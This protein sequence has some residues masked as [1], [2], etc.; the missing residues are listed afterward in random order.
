MPTH[1]V[2]Q[3]EHISSIADQYGF[4]DW[5]KIWN[6][7][8][9]SDLKKKREN[10]HILYPDDELFIPEKEEKKESVSNEKRH[11]FKLKRK[12]LKLRIILKDINDKPLANKKCTLYVG[13]QKFELTSK[14]NGLVEQ[15][16]YP[17]A[18]KANLV[19][20]DNNGAAQMG[21]LIK[22]GHLDPIDTPSGQK[23]RLNNL[24][25]FAGLAEEESDDDESKRRLLAAIEEFQCD[26]QLK[27][28]GICGPN[29]Q[30]KLKEVYGS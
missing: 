3:G 22:I 13:A 19:V 8:N 25:Y 20:H 26:Q 12:P 29:T 28:D 24:G 1:T 2:K 16:I 7:P 21:L 30:A 14:S 23:A 11:K 6:D 5:N 18:E 27:V 9:N 10:P 15:K 17:T 4:G